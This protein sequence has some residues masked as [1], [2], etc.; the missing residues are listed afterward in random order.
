MEEETDLCPKADSLPSPGSQWAI[1]FNGGFRDV[2][3]KEGA[4]P[5]GGLISV[6]LTVL[7]AVNFQFQGQFVP[8][9]LR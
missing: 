5:W 4:R 1:A 6:I 9:S 8:I 3:T 7:S 2:S